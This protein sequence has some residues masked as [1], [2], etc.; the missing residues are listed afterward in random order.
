MGSD[1]IPNPEA[2]ARGDCGPY[3]FTSRSLIAFVVRERDNAV[4][5]AV[6]FA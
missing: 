2:M 6:D 5:A 4:S 3:K 1:V